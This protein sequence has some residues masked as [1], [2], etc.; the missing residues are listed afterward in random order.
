MI[1]DAY[2]NK[3]EENLRLDAEENNKGKGKERKQQ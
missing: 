3:F 1:F 2:M